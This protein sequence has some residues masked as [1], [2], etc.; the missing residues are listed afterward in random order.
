MPKQNP[1]ESHPLLGHLEAVAAHWEDTCSGALPVIAEK[2]P[3]NDFASA[4]KIPL[5]ITVQGVVDNE[6]VDYFA[7]FALNPADGYRPYPAV[8]DAIRI[9]SGA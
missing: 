2:E 4:Q 5:N 3:N 6:D 9:L 1:R 7:L 8:R